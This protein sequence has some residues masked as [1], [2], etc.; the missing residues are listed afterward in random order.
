M[1]VHQRSGFHL[2]ILLDVTVFEDLL[3][4]YNI[5]ARFSLFYLEK[6]STSSWVVMIMKFSC[7]EVFKNCLEEGQIQLLR[8]TDDSDDNESDTGKPNKHKP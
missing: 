8:F 4:I 1:R 3:V 7:V 6:A 5:V 2:M